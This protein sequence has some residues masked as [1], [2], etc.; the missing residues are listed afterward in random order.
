MKKI[1]IILTAILMIASFGAMA[2]VAINTDGSQPD[3]SAMLDIKA[4]DGGLLIPRMT[5]TQRNNISSPAT[6]LIVY[7]TTDN[8]FYYYDGTQWVNWVDATDGD[9]TVSG[10]NIFSA[11]SGNVGIGMTNPIA[12]LQILGTYSGAFGSD[13]L[14]NIK[15]VSG[16]SCPTCGT[17]VV[18]LQTSIDNRTDSYSI[19]AY[20]GVSRHVLSLQPD[21]GYVGIG[22]TTPTSK[23]HV[24]GDTGSVDLLLEA[25]TDNSGEAGQPSITLKQDG[26]TVVGKLGFFNSKNQLTLKNV[27]NDALN[28]GTNDIDR[29]TILGNGNVGIGTSAPGNYK[30][31][32]NGSQYI[33]GNLRLNDDNDIYGIDKLVGHN[34]I[35]FYSDNTGSTELMRLSYSGGLSLGSAYVNTNPGQGSMIISGNVGIG[36]AY[37]TAKLQVNGQLKITGGSPGINKVLTSDAYGLASWQDASSLYDGDWI[38]SGNNMYSAVSG[39]VG[40]GTNPGLYKLNVNGNQYI[41]GHLRFANDHSIFGIDK[42]V[43]YNDLRFYAD[44]NGNSE[45]MH[46]SSTGG[47]SLGS[48]YVT[49]NPG[50]GSMIISGNVGIGTAIP[51]AKLEVNGQL[52]I[53]GGSPGTNKVL[54]SDAYGLASWQDA[55]SLYDGDWTVNG[56]DMYSAVSGNV[57][58]GTTNPDYTFEVSGTGSNRGRIA[59]YSPGD[60]PNDLYFGSN[61]Q[62]DRWSISSR[63]ST[64]GNGYPLTIW[65]NNGGWGRV[66]TIDYT[67][68]NLGIGTATP[69]SYKLNVNGNQYINGDLYLANNKNIFGINKIVGYNDLCFYTDNIGSVERMRISSTGGLSLG[70]SYVSTNPGPGS[71]IISGFMGIG[72]TSPGAKLDVNGAIIARA[73][74]TWFLRGGDDAEFRDINVANFVGIYGRQNSDRVGIRLGSDG[75][76]IYGDNGNIG[77][78]TTAPGEKLD[79]N[80]AMHLTP[81]SAPSNPNEGD[82]Y[83]DSTT[84]KLRCYD[85]TSWHDLW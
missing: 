63:V 83:M 23:L 40:I 47:L 11:V 53:T 51:T 45:L 48:A 36:T 19:R 55:S 69:G 68:G 26:G 15:S 2:Q 16:G 79:V 58:I 13:G 43:G 78:G 18:K 1:K 44:N 27:Y 66:L 52:K 8:K 54:T 20:G 22:T 59:L 39:N 31:Y 7:V 76:Y 82:I 38:V 71:M 28:L 6:G 41:S 60:V 29:L 62:K 72:I 35:R 42:L 75:S 25:D 84:H 57:G 10:S 34:D 61:G 77:I 37:P 73:N 17:E 3:A 4:T 5:A 30:L 56:N 64:D 65:R 80:G 74:N 12:K 21:G 24:S 70:S 49:T 46:L 81:G 50:Q 14:L 85:G 32:V 67:N 9:W 33:G